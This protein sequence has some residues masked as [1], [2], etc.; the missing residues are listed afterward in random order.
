MIGA[1]VAEEVKKQLPRILES[2]LSER[3]LRKMVVEQFAPQ[4]RQAAPAYK[5]IPQRQAPRPQAPP[6]QK[7]TLREVLDDDFFDQDP[8]N[9]TPTSLRND[10]KGIYQGNPLMHDTEEEPQQESVQRQKA[11]AVRRELVA[12][13]PALAMM[14]E[15]VDVSPSVPNAMPDAPIERMGADFGAMREILQRTTQSSSGPMTMPTT[16]EQKMRELEMK[17]KALERP[18]SSVR[19]QG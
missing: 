5:P 14:Y 16:P 18:A 10:H 8:E 3:Y 17:R 19:R 11:E 6:R 1:I 7:L 9:E 13:N 12:A 15:D 4:A 2:T